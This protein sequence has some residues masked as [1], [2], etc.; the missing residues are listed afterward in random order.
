MGHIIC[1]DLKRSLNQSNKVTSRLRQLCV[2]IVVQR[3]EDNWAHQWAEA[4]IRT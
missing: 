4:Y 3:A 2:Q 1:L